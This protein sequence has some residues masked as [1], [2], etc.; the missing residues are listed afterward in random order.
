VLTTGA[1]YYVDVRVYKSA[2]S[3]DDLPNDPDDHKS[4]NRLEWAFGGQSKSTPAQYEGTNLKKP[5]H[6][7]W[8]HW[9]DSKSLDEVKDEGDMYPQPDG[10]VLE[11]GAMANP[12]TGKIT[13][14]EELWQ[15]LEPEP[16]GEGENRVCYVFRLDEPSKTARGMVIRIG[17]YIE[18][19]L[20]IGDH[21]TAVRWQW[22]PRSET[23]SIAAWYRTLAI[24]NGAIPCEA[25]F[26]A[27]NNG[28]ESSVETGQAVL[29]GTG[30]KWTCIEVFSW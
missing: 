21:I 29:D 20:R 11:K 15:D 22:R 8:S 16:T 27:S 5:A 1:K 12:A 14:Y 25:L 7:I 9:V 30:M 3:E 4:I 10:T 2:N 26:T 17:K 24:G 19:V 18:G 28:Q 13:D 23:G 6:T